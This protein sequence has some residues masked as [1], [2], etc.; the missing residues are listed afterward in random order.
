MMPVEKFLQDDDCGSLIDDGTLVLFLPSGGAQLLLGFGSRTVFIMK[1]NG[2]FCGQQSRQGF[3]EAANL[4]GGSSFRAI[5][6]HWQSN[7]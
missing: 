5:F 1:M 3:S 2:E 7:N 4:G 6:T